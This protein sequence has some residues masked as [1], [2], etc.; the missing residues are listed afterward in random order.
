MQKQI[1]DNIIKQITIKDID[2]G[3]KSWFDNT[4]DMH[5]KTPQGEMRKVTVK[6]SSGERWVAAND[7]SGARDKDGRLILP[8]ISIHRKNIDPFNNTTALG[9]NLPRFQIA[10]TV[11]D[12]TIDLYNLDRDRPISDR[13]IRD[14]AIYDVWTIPYPSANNFFYSVKIQTQ[15]NL[16]MNEIVEKIYNRLEFFAVPTFVIDLTFSN[17]EKSIAVGD[18]KSEIIPHIDSSYEL[19]KTLKN[20][21]CVAYI[22][23][24]IQN[25]TNEEN[26]DQERVIELS[27]DIKVPAVLMLDPVGD[28]P[29]VAVEKTAFCLKIGDE[30]VHFVKNKEEADKIFKK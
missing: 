22:E 19:R 25:A 23:G 13:R 28:K 3:I 21:Y 29:A 26:T 12:K 24:S 17:K 15:Y 1:P 9:I 4:L 7:K 14:A 11:S 5:V 6:F 18:G 2:R 27:F 8:L 30:N 16:H 20:H 10:K